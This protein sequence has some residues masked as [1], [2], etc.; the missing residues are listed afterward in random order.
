[1]VQEADTDQ[2]GGD[3]DHIVLH[4]TSAGAG[5]VAHHLVAYGGRKNDLFV[6]AVAQSPYIPPELPVAD[7]EWQFERYI[8]DANCNGTDDVMSCLRTQ[9]IEVLR[10]ANINAPWPG[11]QFISRRS[12][13]PVIDGDLIQDHVLNLLEQGKFVDVPLMTGNVASEAFI[14]VPDAASPVDVKVFFNQYDATLGPSELQSIVERY[15]PGTPTQGRTASFDVINQAYSEATF[16]CPSIHLCNAMSNKKNP[17]V[18]NY[19]FNISTAFSWD[20]G[21]GAYHM[22]DDA[23]IFGPYLYGS[24]LVEPFDSFDAYNRK[25]VDYMMNYYLSFVKT[26]SPNTIKFADAPVF[27]SFVNHGPRQQLDLQ[28]NDT[29]MVNIPSTLLDNCRFWRNLQAA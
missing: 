24:P 11:R 16:I 21:I 17:T 25:Y 15:P 20:H 14:L 12:W 26:L 19:S 1:M 27:G 10:A 18:W 22:I 29:R 6:G 5:S 23:A 28:S 4:G 9:E 7:L 2:F 8:T 13:G 3:P